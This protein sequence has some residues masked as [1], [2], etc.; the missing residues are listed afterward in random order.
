MGQP[1][2]DSG[3]SGAGRHVGAH[4]WNLQPMAAG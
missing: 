3:A 1:M 4:V 2:A